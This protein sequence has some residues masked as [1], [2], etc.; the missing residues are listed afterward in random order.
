M[1]NLVRKIEKK[2]FIKDPELLI[3]FISKLSELISLAEKQ[4]KTYN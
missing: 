4:S 1:K 3:E 2:E